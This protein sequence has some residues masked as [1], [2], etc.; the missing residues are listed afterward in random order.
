MNEEVEIWKDVVGYEGKYQVS[1]FGNVKSLSRLVPNSRGGFKTIPTKILKP[2]MGTSGYLGV[3]LADSGSKT[4][5]IHRLVTI[6]F[7]SNEENKEY[8]NHKDGIK[9]NNHISN[10]EWTT[11]S[12]NTTHAYDNKLNQ[13]YGENNPTSKLTLAQVED[14]IESYI[15]YNRKVGARALGRKYGISVGH[16]FH[17]LAGNCWVR[18]LNDQCGNPAPK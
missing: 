9:T 18:S 10:L 4:Y 5:M 7:I 6:A 16:I 17:I 1:S 12:E 13:N 14:I 11:P 3:N 15:P 2:G 8:V